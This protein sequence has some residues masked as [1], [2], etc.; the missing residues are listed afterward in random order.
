M[1]PFATLAGLLLS[2][3]GLAAY[4]YRFKRWRDRRRPS[5][6]EK[7]GVIGL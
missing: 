5:V 1:A 4:G 2:L 7:R 3:A 6:Y